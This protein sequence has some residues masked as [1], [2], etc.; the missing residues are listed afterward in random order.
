MQVLSAYVLVVLVWSTTP[1]AIQFSNSSLSFVAA[2][3]LRMV[4]ALVICFALLK[5]FRQPLI[6]SRRDWVVYAASGLGLFPNMVLIYWAAQFI[7]SG[8]MS[9]IMGVYPFFVGLLSWGLLREKV[10]TPLKIL[11]LVCAI[12]GLSLIHHD[13][14]LLG[15]EAFKGVLA[16]I[17]VCLIWGISTVL[18][19]KLGTRSSPLQL[20]TGSLLISTPFFLISWVLIDGQIPSGIDA[21]SFWGVAYLVLMGSVVSHTLWFY[22]LKHCSATSVSLVTLMTPILAI[23]WGYVFAG[24]HLTN[25]TLLGG[26]IIV[27]SLMIYQGVLRYCL[28]KLK[29]LFST[30]KELSNCKNYSPQ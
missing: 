12:F 26:V 23:T 29:Y 21:K 11:A 2:I 1:L 25:T 9:I 27:F 14:L 3:T 4:I 20:G 16:L 18:V 15:G 8:L 28:G 19:K 6:Q 5:L 10:F 30:S 13:Q 22:V 24:E 7:P 17:V